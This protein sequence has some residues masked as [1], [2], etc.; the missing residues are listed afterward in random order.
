MNFSLKRVDCV[1]SQPIN[2]RQRKTCVMHIDTY[3]SRMSIQ[4][5]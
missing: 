4:R 3:A 5:R 2:V 1:N